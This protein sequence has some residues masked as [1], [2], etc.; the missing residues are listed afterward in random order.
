MGKRK[1]I[2]TVEQVIELNQQGKPIRKIAEILGLSR[3]T[4]RKYLRERENGQEAVIATPFDRGGWKSQINWEEMVSKRASGYQ[5]DRLHSEFAPDGVSYW[6]FCRAFKK[7][8]ESDIRNI[9]ISQAHK[10]GEK[11]QVDYTD[12]ILIYDRK[13]GKSRKTQFFCGVSAFSG[14][15]FGEFSYD[16][17]LPSFI[18]AHESMWSYFGGVMPYVVP[19]NL[20]SAVSKAHRYDPNLNPTFVDFG[21]HCGFAVLPARPAKPRDKGV[22]EAT[23]GAVQRSFY[24]MHK[25]TRFYDLEELNH[26]FRRFLD[27]FNSKIMKDYGVSRADRFQYERSM[28]LPQP[29]ERY[30]LVEWRN[31]KVH[32][33]CHIQISHSYYSVPFRYVGQQVRVKVSDRLI[34]IYSS[35]I[36]LLTTHIPTGNRGGRSTKQEHLPEEKLQS[37]QFDIKKAVAQAQAIGPAMSDLME[38]IFSGPLPL[39]GLRKAQGILRT[40]GKDGV[41]QASMEYA[42]GQCLTFRKIRTDFF[43]QCALSYHRQFLSQ[44]SHLAPHRFAG[45][46]YLRNDRK[47]PR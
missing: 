42:A 19:D 21:N 10:P 12:G 27:G 47:D 13:S 17:K 3:N 11:V 25:D 31:A 24:Q 22:V 6:A 41:G 7:V 43:R 1:S 15:T 5:L 14:Y 23:I 36:K 32:P 37:C 46:A 26:S 9:V 16:Q 40:W 18:R 35:D 44:G 45:S 4:V 29:R 30:E 8:S 2:L 34:S 38:T 33:D 20:K 28:L 39:T